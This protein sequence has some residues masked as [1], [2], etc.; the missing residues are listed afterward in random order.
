MIIVQTPLRVSLF[1]GGTD[2]PDYFLAHGGC[3]L[4]LAI[5][6]YIY[7]T[8]KKRFDDLIRV[9][10]TKTELVPS[11]D[12]VQHELIREAMRK[13]GITAGVEITTMGDI[14]S[15]G[16]GLG[17]S[18]TVTVGALH[19]MYA[20]QG[21]LVLAEQLAREACEIEVDVLKKPIGFQ[22][23]YI[24]AYGGM[25][26]IEFRPDGKIT[27]EKVDI[28]GCIQR[29]INQNFL[30]F[31]TGITRTSASILNEQKQNIDTRLSVLSEMKDLAY[32]AREALQK[33]NFIAVGRL[34]DQSW[35]LKKQLASQISNNEI[36]DLYTMARKA[37][38]VG[39]KITGAGG[40]GFLLLIC[41]P[42]RQEAVRGALSHLREL[43]FSLEPDGSK[44]IFN[45]RR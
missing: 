16:S 15:E 1:G 26:F 3:V 5:D 22:D 21:R 23:Q 10:Y 11:V 41:P 29:Q 7:V 42:E 28:N 19:A 43:P 2:F 12:Q 25:R 18:S 32:T 13:A 35:Q 36:D 4:S 38:A 44:V 37:G 24:A 9:G 6:K 8:I 20:Y 40:G 39:G 14:P 45:Y 34:L 27:V 17:S 31:F 33:E 30:L